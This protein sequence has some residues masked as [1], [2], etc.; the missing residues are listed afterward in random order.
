MDF[1][2]LMIERTT[3]LILFFAIV[4]QL[5]KCKPLFSAVIFYAIVIKYNP[6]SAE[7]GMYDPR[8]NRV[9]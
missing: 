4:R 3:F 7:M 6:G 9:L 2:A 8:L 5:M 1:P